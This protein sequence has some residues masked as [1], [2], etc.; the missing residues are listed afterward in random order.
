MPKNT[1]FRINISHLQL[2]AFSPY[3]GAPA[4]LRRIIEESPRRKLRTR[5]W[6][7]GNVTQI[8]AHTVYFRFGRMRSVR[9]ADW[10]QDHFVD[11]QDTDA[12]YC[13]VYLNTELEYFSI[14]HNTSVSSSIVNVVRQL[15]Y[16]FESSQVAK[17]FELEFE[18]R[19]IRNP[20]EFVER[21]RR[22][23]IVRRFWF[24]VARPNVLDVN[25][26]TRDF[27]NFTKSIGGRQTKA[28]TEGSINIDDAV[29]LSRVAAS[30]GQDAGAS[31]RGARDR[32]WVR[33]S[34]G[35]N[36]I[37]FSESEDAL[38]NEKV[39]I[40]ADLHR[41]YRGARGSDTN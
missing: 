35:R 10:D 14:S 28:Q 13:H 21:L 1:M 5:V 30:N 24:T 33:A 17:D 12:P 15:R 11:V 27:E 6:L 39:R 4:I 7:L 8:D 29:E 37:E 41:R 36:N 18:I 16:L 38:Q 9:R 40:S 19:P 31:F 22:A 2:N 3:P 26:V 20:V 34:V 25:Q 32:K 23:R